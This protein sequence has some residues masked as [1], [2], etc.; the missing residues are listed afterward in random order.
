MGVSIAL[1]ASDPNNSNEASVRIGKIN[2]GNGYLPTLSSRRSG[3]SVWTHA[4]DLGG[5]TYNMGVPS[6]QDGDLLQFRASDS[7]WHPVS[8]VTTD[9]AI[10]GVTLRFVNG[11]FLGQV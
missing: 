3:M 5:I 8:G 2:P 10:G 4:L 9:I 7:T 1:F 6:V 11:V